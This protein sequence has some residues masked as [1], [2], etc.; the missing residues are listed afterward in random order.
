MTGPSWLAGTFAA[1]MIVIAAYSASRLVFSQL[2]VRATEYDA[3]ALPIG[4]AHRSQFSNARESG[5]RLTS[6][7]VDGPSWRVPWSLGFVECQP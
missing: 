1:V 5:L 7:M 3:D 4:P 6:L 2:R